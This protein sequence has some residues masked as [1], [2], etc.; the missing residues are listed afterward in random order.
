MALQS[1]TYGNSGNAYYITGADPINPSSFTAL[2]GPVEILFTST[3]AGAYHGTLDQTPS[4]FT[5]SESDA[6]LSTINSLVFDPVVPKTVMNVYDV[7]N[8]LA[9][10][11]IQ[12]WTN[13]SSIVNGTFKVGN[14]QLG[15]ENN[16]L[17]FENLPN[18]FTTVSQNT[19]QM[20]MDGVNERTRFLN[21]GG[22]SD[23]YIEI[24]QSAL[25]EGTLTAINDSLGYK[26]SINP[27][28]QEFIKAGAV[29]GRTGVSSGAPNQYYMS[30]RTQMDFV[31]DEVGVAP[32]VLSLK[33]NG[34]AVFLSTVFAPTI[35]TT[36][37]RAVDI[38]TTNIVGVNANFDTISTLRV[39]QKGPAG[40]PIFVGGSVELRRVAGPNGAA[41]INALTSP[42][43]IVNDSGVT[44][45]VY[46][47]PLDNQAQLQQGSIGGSAGGP[48]F[49]PPTAINS[50]E[51]VASSELTE[52]GVQFYNAKSGTAPPEWMGGFLKNPK[53]FNVAPTYTANL[54]GGVST[55][56][57]FA[58]TQV[59]TPVVRVSNFINVNPSGY[60]NVGSNGYISTPVPNATLSTITTNAIAQFSHKTPN[61]VITNN[62]SATPNTP[63]PQAYG[64]FQGQ[65]M[66]N[67]LRSTFGAPATAFES[68]EVV[69]VAGGPQTG[70]IQF[71]ASDNSAPANPLWMG[72]FLKNNVGAGQSEFRLA[73]TITASM[74]QLRDVSTI[75]F[76]PLASYGNP[77]GTILNWAGFN[78]SAVPT[79][80]L[81]CD[82]RSYPIAGTYN[83]LYNVIGSWGPAS[84]GEFKVPDSRGRVL[85]GSLT[86]PSNAGPNGTYAVTAEYIQLTTITLPASYGGGTRTGMIVSN[87]N[88][89]LFENMNIN[90][91]GF[92]VSPKILGFINSDGIYGNRRQ[93][94]LSPQAKKVIVLFDITFPTPSAPVNTPITFEFP[95][96]TP[97]INVPFIRNVPEPTNL[98][99]QKGLGTYG[100]LQQD[101]EVGRHQHTAPQPGGGASALSGGIRAGDPNIS[102]PQVSN[103]NDIF[104]YTDLVYG[105]QNAP[106]AMNNIPYNMATWQ[107]IKF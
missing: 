20:T 72:G 89:Q 62:N 76:Q 33:Q 7:N 38:S 47:A 77:V 105:T 19:A 6:N 107:I 87:L 31:T 100:L 55:T 65:F 81:L 106:L 25:T 48:P 71:Y 15:T 36:T 60:I 17:V 14:K 61:S 91:A 16:A 80:Y 53:S 58:N 95:A 28:D 45:K 35:S 50:L 74:P 75:N 40:Q 92:S 37:V 8:P 101:Y 29:Y 41:G 102:G 18:G 52:G 94:F 32:T 78:A 99:P 23:K 68:L 13:V 21:S 22:F 59:S 93:N 63:Y 54:L 1:Q 5:I 9:E 85:T 11:V 67:T 96:L 4:T 88:G 3:I 44:P 69:N 66:Y 98:E 64:N 12:Q 103:N 70:G 104:S 26:I 27:D 43:V 24:G 84:A 97:T 51:I 30:A 42:R 90:T 82:G 56:S 73:S 10:P 34:T 57:L 46:F 39:N 49:A 86:I 79:G 2:Y 83:A